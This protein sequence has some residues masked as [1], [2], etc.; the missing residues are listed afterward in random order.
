M[1]HR[2]DGNGNVKYMNASNFT[3]FLL[4]NEQATVDLN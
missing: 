2:D 4:Q 3:D 1:S